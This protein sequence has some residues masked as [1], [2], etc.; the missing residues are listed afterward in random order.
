ML[1]EWDNVTINLKYVTHILRIYDELKL[2]VYFLGGSSESMSVYGSYRDEEELDKD[3]N[4]LI[5][6]IKSSTNLN[7]D[8]EGRFLCNHCGAPNS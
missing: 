3:Y 7:I 1:V 8:G 2:E 6:L 5:K 4:L